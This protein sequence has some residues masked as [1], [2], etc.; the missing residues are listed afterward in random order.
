MRNDIHDDAARDD[1]IARYLKAHP[2][3]FIEHGDVLLGATIPAAH[4]GRA[5]SLH[6]RQLEVLR[7]RNRVLEARLAELLRI[8]QEN[9]SLQNKFQAW[10]CALLREAD[11][12]RLAQSLCDSLAEAFNVPQV[13]LRVWRVDAVYREL[14]QAA[15]VSD[16]VI[17]LADGMKQPYC[18]PS[19]AVL[20]AKWLPGDGARTRSIALLPLRV[21]DAGPVF[22][23]L[24]LGSEDIERFREGM[25]TAILAR[26]AQAASAAL[27][28]LR[29]SPAA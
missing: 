17:T 1:E 22:G 23:L 3:F 6:E 10:T 25:G 2:R 24:V 14:P 15:P 19:Q 13:A 18:G 29:A 12:R 20:P 21:D 11:D 26:I 28:R 7:E 8:G 4:G 5:I 27:A 9:D 16:D